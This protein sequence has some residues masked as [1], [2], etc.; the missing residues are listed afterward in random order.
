MEHREWNVAISMI[1]AW[2]LYFS[3]VIK[4]VRL[5]NDAV[6]LQNLQNIDSG[7]KYDY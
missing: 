6:S 4:I 1:T 5:F 3:S 2:T 7:F